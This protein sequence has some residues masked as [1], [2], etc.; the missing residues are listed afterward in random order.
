M[1]SRNWALAPARGAVLSY[2]KSILGSVHCRQETRKKSKKGLDARERSLQ[3]SIVLL[4]GFY[5]FICF[6]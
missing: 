2:V 3:S 5:P 4:R 1:F 6:N